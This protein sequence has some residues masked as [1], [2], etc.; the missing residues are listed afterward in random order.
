[1]MFKIGTKIVYPAHGVGVVEKIEEKEM[2]GKTEHCYIIRM[3]EGGMTIMVPK[4]NAT[5]IGIRKVIDKKDVKK[6]LTIL[7]N[8][9]HDS[10]EMEENWNR[11]HKEYIEKIKTGSVFEVA[12]VYRDLYLL[13]SEKELSFGER[14]V[15]DNAHQLIVSEIA[16]AK[17]INEEKAKL[18]LK[19]A[20]I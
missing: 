19:N 17:G 1:M 12:K 16:E 10:S 7:R 15:L 4:N 14:Q 5:K 3:S 9:S 2:S 11:R 6:I 20:M 8:D 18:L 13:K